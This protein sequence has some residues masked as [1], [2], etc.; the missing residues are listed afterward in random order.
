MKAQK[1]P[2]GIETFSIIREDGFVYVDKTEYIHQ[3]VSGSGLYFLSRPRR[4]GKSLLLSTI[5]AFFTGRRELFKGLAID[6]YD[7]SWERHPVFR[8]NFVNAAL[9]SVDG[10][11]SLMH[12]YLCE[13]ESKY[14]IT[15]TGFDYPQRFQR[16]IEA[17]V[18]CTGKKAVILIDE[19]DKALVSSLDDAELNGQFRAFLK[20]IYGTLKAAG[21]HIRFALITGVSRFSRLS[22]FSDINNLSDISL[23]DRF[24]AICGITEEE[25]LTQCQ[26]GIRELAEYMGVD[27][28]HMTQILKRQ[29]DGYHFTPGCPDIY[30][31][32]SL[33]S[34]FQLK[35]I[36][37]YWFATGTPT[38]LIRSLRNSDTYLPDL[39]H[40][41]ADVTELSDIDSY[42]SSAI[43]LLFQTGYL[44]IKRFDPDY[45][46]YLLGL[47]NLEVANGF[48]KDLLPEYMDTSKS[49][50]FKE[51]RAFIKDVKEGDP[52]SFIIRLQSFLADIPY[53]I[54]KC[55]PEIYF[56]N[57][58]YIIFKLMG[59]TID[60]EYR[61]A[62]GRIDLLLRTD[63]FIYLMELKLNG[64]PEEAISQI[65]SK[66]YLI[67]FSC[68]NRRL[69]KI[70]ISFS[71]ATRNIDRWLIL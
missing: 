32:F 66:D 40:N 25:M 2:V 44:T 29:Y 47:P 70:G 10:L 22:I 31:P 37:N 60:A 48:F 51:I 24:A 54:S 38:F 8:L 12:S 49:A 26:G 53:E 11:K 20:P 16:C 59:F 6:S 67:P 63:R 52:E 17:A 27:Y 9:S 71:S 19:Y 35:A 36:D 7:H 46:T 39:L 56:E 5:E 55:K 69:F 1:F 57:N 68:D 28:Y 21:A 61:T 50:G 30:N 18:N 13:W 64:T 45:Q 15:D 65:D 14:G 58:L 34:A 4:F 23:S 42:Q 62:S 33:F 43:G 3:L 41:E